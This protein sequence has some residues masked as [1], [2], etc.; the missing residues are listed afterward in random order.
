M[1]R[2]RRRRRRRR[3]SYGGRGYSSALPACRW[4]CSWFK[5]LSSS[6]GGG[7]LAVWMQ[8]PGASMPAAAGALKLRKNKL[9]AMAIRTMTTVI[10]AVTTSTWTQ[11][12][13]RQL[14]TRPLSSLHQW[15]VM[16]V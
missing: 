8:H 14:P 16:L 4:H 15:S 1:T 3:R 13:R 10:L 5:V 2:T 12:R 7:R 6:S 11:S 9:A